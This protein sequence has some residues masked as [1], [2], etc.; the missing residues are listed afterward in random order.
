MGLSRQ[1]GRTRSDDARKLG[2]PREL[3]VIRDRPRGSQETNEFLALIGRPDTHFR[4]ELE[5]TL[6]RALARACSLGKSALI[7][8]RSASYSTTLRTPAI[9][10]Q[11]TVYACFRLA[12]SRGPL[13]S[14]WP[15]KFDMACRLVNLT[16]IWKAQKSHKKPGYTF[17]ECFRLVDGQVHVQ[18]V[19]S[20]SCLIMSD[21]VWTFLNMSVSSQETL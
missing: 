7:L 3:G 10:S 5:R 17:S 8:H 14:T 13:W 16:S 9:Q 12:I 2:R 20:R 6:A 21:H 15:A 1:V 18:L 11:E 4:G 19:S